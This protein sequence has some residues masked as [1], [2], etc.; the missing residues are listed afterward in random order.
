MH[1]AHT[2]SGIALATVLW[3]TATA[4]CSAAVVGSATLMN[5][6]VY[7]NSAG[8]SI[9]LVAE[10][11]SD[12]LKRRGCGSPKK[13]EVVNTAVIDAN[14]TIETFVC[15]NPGGDQT[16]SFGEE[17]GLVNP[18]GTSSTAEAGEGTSTAALAGIGASV[19]APPGGSPVLPPV[20]SRTPDRSGPPMSPN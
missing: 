3:A 11:D 19:G 1:S 7:R 4:T 13:D 18:D 20:H 12:R 14:G 8:T 6:G 2:F 15:P 9:T 17:A 10:E 5:P 16:L